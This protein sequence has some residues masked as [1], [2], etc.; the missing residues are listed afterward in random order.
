MMRAVVPSPVGVNR[1]PRVMVR[2]LRVGM[3]VYE[4][5]AQSSGL[6]GRREHQG[7]YFPHDVLIVRDPRS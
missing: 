6:D 3:C 1:P 4:R 5:G 2:R 7:E